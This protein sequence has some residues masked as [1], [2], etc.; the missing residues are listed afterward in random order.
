[1][2]SHK[3]LWLTG[4]FVFIKKFEIEKQF[5]AINFFNF[6]NKKYVVVR[7]TGFQV[8]SESNSLNFKGTL[9]KMDSWGNF[10]DY[11]ANSPVP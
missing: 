7:F 9:R 11:S 6:V 8:H 2:T 4:I 3:I 5:F 1:M 10:P